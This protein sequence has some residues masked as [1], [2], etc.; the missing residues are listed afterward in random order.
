MFHKTKKNIKKVYR[1]S[2]KKTQKNNKSIQFVE[3]SNTQCLRR[4]EQNKLLK[5]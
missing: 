2:D 4:T 3:S 1:Q 5:I